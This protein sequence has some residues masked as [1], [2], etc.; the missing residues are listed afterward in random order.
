MLIRIDST[1][2]VDPIT[3]AAIDT[4]TDTPISARHHK[5]GA[6]VKALEKLHDVHDAIAAL[7]ACDTA[8]PYVRDFLKTEIPAILPFLAQPTPE[9]KKTA[10]AK[11]HKKP[12]PLRTPPPPVEAPISSITLS[13]SANITHNADKDGIE[14]RFNAK[15]SAE[16]INALKQKGFRWS[17][18]QS[19]WYCPY[20]PDTLAWATTTLN[21]TGATTTPPADRI[22]STQST[23]VTP[24]TPR[25]P[26]SVRIVHTP[27]GVHAVPSPPA[28]RIDSTQSTPVTPPTTPSESREAQPFTGRPTPAQ[29]IAAMLAAKKQNA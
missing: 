18:R 2:S 12:T 27:D 7:R 25:R 21:A 16:T 24:V 13:A 29:L 20:T 9:R 28:D 15:P 22:D 5:A 17:G 11:P 23:P 10:D 26:T 14:V 6:A 19:L 3:G 8:L 4:A 1:L